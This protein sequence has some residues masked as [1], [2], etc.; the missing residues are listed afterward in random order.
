MEGLRELWPDSDRRQVAIVR[1]LQATVGRKV[2]NG[3]SSRPLPRAVPHELAPVDL[4]ILQALSY[5]LRADEAAKA[6]GLERHHVEDRLRRARRIMQAKTT[7]GACC[8]A[9]R[10]GLIP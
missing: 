6:L 3:H 7:T 4:R 10:K 8:D 9:I 2:Q 5:G 1:I